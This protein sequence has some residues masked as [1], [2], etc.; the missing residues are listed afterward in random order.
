MTVEGGGVDSRVLVCTVLFTEGQN[1]CR[2]EAWGGYQV[3]A[4]LREFSRGSKL[5]MLL[6]CL[7]FR[8]MP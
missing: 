4:K 2:L 8:T 6:Q 7:P 1:R 3:C 5:F